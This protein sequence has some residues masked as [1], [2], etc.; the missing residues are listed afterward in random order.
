[1]YSTPWK[2]V[3]NKAN[4]TVNK[5]PYKDPAL[6][7]CIIQWWPYVTVKPDES[8]NIEFKRGSSK[9]FTVSTPL[10]GHFAPISTG[11]PTA[12]WKKLQNMLKKKSAS[13]TIN[14]A[15]PI[16]SPLCTANVWSPKY[17][18]SDI[19][20]LN[21]NDIEKITNKKANIKAICTDGKP[22]MVKTPEQVSVKIEMEV[23]IGQ[24]EGETKWNGWAW[25]L[26]LIKCVISRSK[27]N[28]RSL[29]NV[30]YLSYL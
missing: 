29:C 20:S 22:C 10:G 17:V 9:G 16:L 30:Y 13:L 3:K 1:M 4:I 26:L 25:K 27:Y 6:L 24:G 19:M 23:N 12:L 7:P 11:G 5:T 21:H 28:N 14:K 8:N 15:T 18:P 2:I